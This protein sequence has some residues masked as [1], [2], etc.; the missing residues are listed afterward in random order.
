MVKRRK[1]LWVTLISFLLVAVIVWY[2]KFKTA[3]GSKKSWEPHSLSAICTRDK[4]IDLGLA[5]RQI[6]GENNPDSLKGLLAIE[7]DSPFTNR[8][9]QLEER[10]S[11]D[12][13]QD[14]TIMIEGWLLSI[15]EARQCALLSFEAT[16]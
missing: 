8:Q 13:K 1:F 4:M 3:I 2:Y 15:T 11:E 16:E 6:T 9:K 7:R 10:I 12:F 5:Y 14:H